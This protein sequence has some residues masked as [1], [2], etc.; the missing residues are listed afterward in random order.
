MIEYLEQ[1]VE[2]KKYREALDL[3]ERL[4]KQVEDPH[5]VVR[6]YAARVVSH[7][8]L[9]EFSEALPGGDF[10]LHL[11]REL[12]DWDSFGML[13]LYVGVAYSRLGQLNEAVTRMYDYLAGL[14]NYRKAAEFEYNAW[15]NL[16]TFQVMLNKPVDAAKA[17]AN[18]LKAAL[19]NGE[20]RYAHGVRQALVDAYLRAEMYE[21]VPRL[22]VQCGHYL[23]KHPELPLY[24]MS[25]ANHIQLRGEYA[26]VTG[27]AT[28][29]KALASRALSKLRGEPY[30][31]LP[32]LVLAKVAQRNGV[33]QEA[34]GH[35]LAA[36]T[37]ALVGRRTDFEQM[38]S[39]LLYE[40]TRA[41]PGAIEMV[42]QYYT[43]S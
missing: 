9:G 36:R 4:I 23:R 34:L 42:D 15:Y 18:A 25:L 3:A 19:R 38:A 14:G 12:G 16:G 26:L 22:L 40:L 21:S 2:E 10:A 11:A 28:R 32:H 27:R 43:D 41:Y 13:A 24:N 1:L 5:Q 31:C 39:D 17:L 30:E 6:I 8:R 29:A 20:H 7:C 33:Y 35:A 37:C